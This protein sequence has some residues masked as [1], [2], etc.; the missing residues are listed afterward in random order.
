MWSRT[1]TRKE[2]RNQQR[3]NQQ[4]R[5]QG[6]RNPQRRNQGRRNRGENSLTDAQ[7]S[8]ANA[9]ATLLDNYNNGLIGPGHCE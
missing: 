4:R 8:Q 3:R 6:R 1:E 5:N 9:W 7:K 2:R